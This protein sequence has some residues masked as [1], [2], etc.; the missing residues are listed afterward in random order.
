MDKQVPSGPSG[1]NLVERVKQLDDVSLALV[2]LGVVAAA[3]ASVAVLVIFRG[4]FFKALAVIV[5]A[6]A[7]VAIAFFTAKATKRAKI[8]REA[9]AEY[10]ALRYQR[11]IDAQRQK[12]IDTVR[13]IENG[14]VEPIADVGGLLLRNSEIPWFKSGC[15][16]NDRKGESHR[17]EFFVTSLRVTFI[18]NSLPIEIPIAHINAVNVTQQGISIVGKS[19]S[20]SAE[21]FLTK[22]EIAAAHVRRA[23]QV[24]HRQVDVG[25]ESNNSRTISQDVK[26]AVYQR[27]NGKCRECEATDYLEY[28]HIIPW[29]KGGANTVDN[30]QILCRRC[31]LKKGN[32]V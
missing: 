20:A 32:S 23:V 14:D 12:I 7:M 25:F 5:L 26:T 1:Q 4:F 10:D 2:I 16:C 9:R 30:I 31:N 11:E 3:V 8:K 6:G 17:G 22:A 18:S 27:D 28:D 21:F 24:Y 29:S 19:T 13:C 15:F